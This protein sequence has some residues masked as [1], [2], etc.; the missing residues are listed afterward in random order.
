LPIEVEHK[1]KSLTV[2]AEGGY[3]WNEHRSSEALYWFAGEYEF[4]EKFSLMAE[5]YGGFDRALEN[6]R[7]SFNFGFRRSLTEHVALIGSAGR[8]ILGP[9]ESA[10]A[11]MSYLALQLTF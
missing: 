5:L 2:Y 7:L 9:P 6:N 1:F 11:F 8:G 3:I 4:S 10:P